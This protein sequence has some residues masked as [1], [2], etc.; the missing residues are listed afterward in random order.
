[1]GNAAFGMMNGTKQSEGGAF[2]VEDVGA[3]RYAVWLSN[4]P[5]GHYVA[6]IRSGTEDVLANGL[7]TSAPVAPLEIVVRPNAG[8][9]TGT[10]TDPSAHQPAAGATVVLVP[11]DVGRRQQRAFY[12]VDSADPNGRFT[13]KHLVPGAYLLFAFEDIDTTAW[14]DPEYMKPFEAR[15]TKVTIREG[16]NPPLEIAVIPAPTQ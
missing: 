10:V 16:P 15:G 1:V 13:L 12:S 7:D 2:R 6:S 5:Q 9:M 8:Q 11:E 14:L 3:E 4:L